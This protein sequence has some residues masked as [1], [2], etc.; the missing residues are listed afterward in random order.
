MELFGLLSHDRLL[1][2]RVFSLLGLEWT[3][4]V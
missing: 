1:R 2:A 3:E 4:A